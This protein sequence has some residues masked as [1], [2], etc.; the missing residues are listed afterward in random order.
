MLTRL[1]E[2]IETHN[3]FV[4]ERKPNWLRSLG[5]ALVYLGLSCRQTAE[6]LHFSDDASHETVRQWYHRAHGLLHDPSKQ[7]RP[8]VAINETKI[9]VEGR[10][11]YLW[12]AIDTES[13]ELLGIAL[14]PTRDGRDASRFIRRVLKT[15]TNTPTVLV[16][17]GRGTR[18]CSPG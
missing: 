13:S 17:E 2:L 7:H 18:G 6:V 11:Y 3:V 9:K 4:R 5:I 12:A 8:T 10:W 14:T 15:C 1:T 16:D